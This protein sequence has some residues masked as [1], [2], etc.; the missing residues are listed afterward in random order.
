M[1]VTNILSSLPALT[2]EVED[3]KN[4]VTSLGC[5]NIPD[6]RYGDFKLVVTFKQGGEVVRTKE[7]TFTS[8][9]TTITGR[10]S[11]DFD[12]AMAQD[13]AYIEGSYL[14]ALTVVGVPAGS[15]TVETQIIA[16]TSDGNG[17]NIEV[18]SEIASEEISVYDMI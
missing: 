9:A 18:C 12:T 15:Y 17:G 2:V 10:A 8:V 6:L 11:T 3:D 4:T 14:V 7:Q 13:V 1:T 5:I 16:T